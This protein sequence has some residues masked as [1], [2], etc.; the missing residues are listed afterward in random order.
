MITSFRLLVTH[1]E[2]PLGK[3]LA[4]I[5]CLDR[6]KWIEERTGKEREHLFCSLSELGGKEREHLILVI[7]C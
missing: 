1:R 2:Y 3:I 6:W 5:E 4:L 7:N